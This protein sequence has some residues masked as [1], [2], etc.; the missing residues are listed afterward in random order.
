[1]NPLR[2]LA[3]PRPFVEISKATN[4]EIKERICYVDSM[5]TLSHFKVSEAE[6]D[7]L[8]SYRDACN[9]LAESSDKEDRECAK[10]SITDYENS[11]RE[12]SDPPRLSFDLATKTKLGE[13]LDNLWNMWTFTRYEKYLPDQVM[14]EAKRHSSSKVSDPWHR[15]FWKPF[16]GRLEA[17]ADAFSMVLLG[18]NAHNKCPTFL[19]LALLCERHTLDWDDT[20]ELIKA[21][22]CDGDVI[23]PKTDLVELIQ[24][25]DA[26]L[27]AKRLDHDEASISL[28]VEHVMGVATMV[29]AFFATHLPEALYEMEEF[30]ATK[31][32]P[33]KLLLDLF[34]LKEG[35]EQAIKELMQE[36]YDKMLNAESD[37]DFDDEE[38]EEEEEEDDDD[39]EAAFSDES[40]DY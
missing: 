12:N 21:C 34:Q 1:M 6:H 20:I 24:T 33:K 27:L 31:W 26:A 25:R 30:D 16:N 5:T 14:Q 37:D 38:W 22:A 32:E 39:D 19:L 35:H 15:E 8:L 40:E 2:Y 17:E 29:L 36:M 28:S 13:E 23:I 3:P 11:L 9:T 18:K 4:K 7:R 10:L